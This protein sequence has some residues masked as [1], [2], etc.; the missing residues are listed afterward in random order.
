MQ[1]AKR[2][3]VLPKKPK[4]KKISNVDSTDIAV[5]LESSDCEASE[6]IGSLNPVITESEF[7]KN[8]I[9]DLLDGVWVSYFCT[10]FSEL[11]DFGI[12]EIVKFSYVHFW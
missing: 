7:D 6:N 8:I 9:K 4:I 3:R 2:L 10:I 11:L 5:Q 12:M 1:F